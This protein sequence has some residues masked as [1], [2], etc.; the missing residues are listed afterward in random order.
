MPSCHPSG[1]PVFDDDLFRL[2]MISG[3]EASIFPDQRWFPASWRRPAKRCPCNP[4]NG[5]TVTPTDIAVDHPMSRK[6][7]TRSSPT[8]VVPPT[9]PLRLAAMD[10]R[11]PCLMEGEPLISSLDSLHGGNHSC[12][13]TVCNLIGDP[14][15]IE[16]KHTDGSCLRFSSML[17]NETL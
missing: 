11:H 15:L 6:T 13:P 9:L 17:R 12:S 10:R 5:G 1:P 3:D 2:N 7:S 8:V 14:I 4:R 16:A